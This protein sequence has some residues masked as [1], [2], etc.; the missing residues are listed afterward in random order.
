MY[1]QKYAFA[2]FSLSIYQ[3]LQENTT[4]H[5]KHLLPYSIH[6]LTIYVLL[7]VAIGHRGGMET[8]L[9]DWYSRI[10]AKETDH[11]FAL[12]VIDLAFTITYLG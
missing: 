12:T 7:H 10:T 5:C 9:W 4:D 8:K 2:Y 3:Q 1:L 11:T 6:L